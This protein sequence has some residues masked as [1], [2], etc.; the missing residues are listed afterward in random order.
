MRT[1]ASLSGL[2]LALA[3]SA[4]ACTGV[5]SGD[6]TVLGAGGGAAEG[7]VRPRGACAPVRK[8][9]YRRMNAREFQAAVRDLFEVPAL[10]L[11]EYPQDFFSTRGFDNDDINTRTSPVDAEKVF[12][13]AERVAGQVA[14]APGSKFGACKTATDLRACLTPLLTSTLRRAYRAPVD[15]TVLGALLDVAAAAPDKGEGIA[16]AIAAMLASP[17]FVMHLVDYERNLDKDGTHELSP[18]ELASRLS[19]FLW[20]SVPDDQLLDLAD[21][22]K[23]RDPAVLAS[24]VRRMLADA[25]ASRFLATFP[26]QWLGYH[27]VATSTRDAKTYPE[28]DDTLKR[29]MVTESNMLF[30][31]VLKSG[32]PA[33]TLVT[34]THSFVDRSLASLYGV[35]FP[36]DAKD[37]FARVSLEGTRRRGLMMQA[38]TMTATATG[39][40]AIH[41]GVFV[42]SRVLCEPLGLP[43]QAVSLKPGPAARTERE[44][45]AAH[46]SD[47]VCNGCH[48]RIDPIGLSYSNFDAIGRFRRADEAGPIDA[49]GK[50]PDGRAFGD[51]ADLASFVASGDT[52]EI[53]LANHLASF[54]TARI[55][56]GDE[57]CLL[58]EVVGRGTADGTTSI[59]RLISELVASDLF[60]LSRMVER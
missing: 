17:R 39:N 8:T 24:E 37:P 52:F 12:T 57:M 10:E 41:R 51:A 5:I 48:A 27:R 31:D 55:V 46:A 58:K 38:A 50:L 16:D 19:F 56:E 54:A 35:P 1:T 28:F 33:D 6:D 9:A 26:S 13:A 3:L 15:P 2:T 29:S 40:L 22:T 14:S 44:K 34:A 47:P 43:P 7:T 18:H 23:L 59:P 4:A 25:R 21:S 11:G 49:S 60:S 30:D 42:L 20:S 53:C 32:A 36:G 45:L